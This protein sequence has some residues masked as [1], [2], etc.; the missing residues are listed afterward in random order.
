[1]TR[2]YKH[3]TPAEDDQLRALRADGL[4]FPEIARRMTR[5][6]S[7][8]AGRCCTL[9]IEPVKPAWTTRE[10]W[11]ALEMRAQ[12]RTHTEIGRVLGRKPNAVS[13]FLSRHRRAQEVNP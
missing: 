10:R 13:V 2:A 11:I 1:M 8:I 7:S 6:Y 12:G 4:L 3:W 9:E 5:T